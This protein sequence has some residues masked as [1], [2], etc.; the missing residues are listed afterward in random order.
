MTNYQNFPKHRQNGIVI[1]FNEYQYSWCENNP[2]KR[3]YL[4]ES[5]YLD[6]AIEVYVWEN[7]TTYKNIEDFKEYLRNKKDEGICPICGKPLVRRQS[8]NDPLYIFLGC[9]G[10]PNC[11]FTKRA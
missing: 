10:W 8:H 5:R 11:K 2:R 9:S 7:Y 4:L 6:K 1:T 3:K